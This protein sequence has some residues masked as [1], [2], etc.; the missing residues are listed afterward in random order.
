M[1]RTTSPSRIVHFTLT[2]VGVGDCVDDALSDAINRLYEDPSSAVYGEI[3]YQHGSSRKGSM[4]ILIEP[5]IE[6]V[7]VEGL[8]EIEA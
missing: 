1:E 8:E 4:R 2:I 6:G 7:I 3:E 5:T